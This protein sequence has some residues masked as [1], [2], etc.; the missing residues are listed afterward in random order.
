MWFCTCTVNGV[1]VDS[2]T[3]RTSNSHGRA[4]TENQPALYPLDGTC[5]HGPAFSSCSSPN[6]LPI[7]HITRHPPLLLFTYV[8]YNLASIREGAFLLLVWVTSINI[9]HSKSINF[10]HFSFHMSHRLC[11]IHSL[12]LL[13]AL[14]LINI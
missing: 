6:M 14:L 7:L 10:V 4:R 13:S 2:S 9:I 3:A 12:P 1:S 5:V 8:H 11:C